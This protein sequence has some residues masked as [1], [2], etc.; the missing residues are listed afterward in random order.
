MAWIA[1]VAAAGAA[2]AG[3]A[4]AAG[5]QNKATDASIAAYQQSVKDLEAIGIPSVEAQQITMQ[6]YQ[7]Q[8]EWT[9]ELAS[10]VQQGPSQME[11][12]STDP[13]YKEA[14]L[15]ALNSL[16]DISSSGGMTLA[17]RATQEKA[18]S[19]S[20]Q[21][22]RG[23]REAILQRAKES[24]TLGSGTTL[25]AQLINSQGAADR[26]H[27]AGLDAAASAQQ[28]ALQAIQSAG[29]L[30]GSMQAT[31]FGQKS[32]VAKA[33]DAIN[34]WNAQNSQ[35]TQNTNVA[36]KNTAS[37]YNLANKQNLSNANTDLANKQE[38]YN[39][40]LQQQQYQNQMQNA[41]AKANARAGQATQEQNGANNTANLWGGVGSSVA[42]AATAAGQ[43]ANDQD[44]AAKK[45][46][47][48][49]TTP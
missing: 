1:P 45:K 40:G 14:Q 9:P 27:A 32:D 18:L 46:A 22:E 23:A 24:G 36:T 28:R 16:K 19:T 2:V 42:Q 15:N 49:T 38:V 47:A 10:A 21:Q 31:E 25:A 4:M 48:T 33:Q 6:K 29:Q 20:A 43:Y 3:G 35:N 12:I 7:D 11:G 39:K 5:A 44:A 17:D 30:G 34:A 26:T 8:G 41:A 13:A 37:Q